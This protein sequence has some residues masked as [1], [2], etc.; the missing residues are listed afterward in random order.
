MVPSTDWF[1]YGFVRKEAV[2]TSQIEGTQ[3][4][5]PDVVT[6]EAADRLCSLEIDV[7]LDANYRAADYSRAADAARPCRASA[8]SGT[9][10]EQGRARGVRCL[11]SWVRSLIRV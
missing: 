8:V 9:N 11:R 5:L 7:L 1:L 10:H 2:I 4:T 6:F 3:A